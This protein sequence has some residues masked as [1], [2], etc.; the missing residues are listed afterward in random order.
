MESATTSEVLLLAS[1]FQDINVSATMLCASQ[2]PLTG[3]VRQ[4]S[5]KT[6]LIS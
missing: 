5:L 1:Q 4:R 6:L 3:I 2:G